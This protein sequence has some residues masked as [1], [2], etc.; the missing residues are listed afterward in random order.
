MG[1]AGPDSDWEPCRCFSWASPPWEHQGG[2]VSLAEVAEPGGMTAPFIAP[3]NFG[4]R[5][6]GQPAFL[7]TLVQ[8]SGRSLTHAVSPA[9]SEEPLAPCSGSELHETAIGQCCPDSG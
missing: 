7:A 1:A 4:M 6:A 2:A 3:G 9:P 5:P 8:V